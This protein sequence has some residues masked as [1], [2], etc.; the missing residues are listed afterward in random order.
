MSTYSVYKLPK[1][2]L[3]NLKLKDQRLDDD[4]ED[5]VDIE[6]VAHSDNELFCQ[7]CRFKAEREHFRSDWHRYN[8]KKKVQMQNPITLDEFEEKEDVSSIDSE[9][10]DEESLSV[11]SPQ[12]HFQLNETLELKVYKQILAQE[13]RFVKNWKERL[14]NLQQPNMKF[15]IIMIASGHFSGAVI[16][17][18]TGKFIEHKTF[19]RY[20]TR[21]KQGGAQSSK[22]SKAKSA[23]GQI[24]KYNENALIEEIQALLKE[25]KP[26][27]QQSTLI[28]VRA[29]AVMRRIIYFDETILRPTDDRVRSFPFTTKRPTLSEITRCYELITL[30]QPTIIIKEEVRLLKESRVEKEVEQTHL[31]FEPEETIES[32]P[33]EHELKLIEAIKKN[34]LEFLKQNM[35]EIN[36]IFSDSYGV[37]YLH[38]AACSPNLEIID[39]LLELG[40]DP[41]IKNTKGARAYDYSSSKPVRDVFRRFMY[42]HPTKY[43]Y[44]LAN[45][46]APL[47]PEMEEQQLEKER[48]K[49]KK[50][51]VKKKLN[52][53]KAKEESV[54]ELLGSLSKN[55]TVMKLGVMDKQTLGMTP[56]EKMRF[57]REKRAV[58]A[59]SRFRSSQNKCGACGKSLE[60]IQSFDKSIYRYC[61][62]D[63]LKE[64]NILF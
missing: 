61:S 28:F 2:V 42:R 45:I 30:V 15:T 63:C 29:P 43:D 53:P 22:G 11:G 19:H 40:C 36:T 16:D 49:K 14:E 39:Y 27:I 4:E 55:I 20:T 44:K 48:T 59:E 1:E 56:E 5:K 60:G 18:D 38:I 54:P 33:K 23:G 35:K 32:K 6:P 37:T 46:P 9:E 10:T 13:G 21:R 64:Q 58:S 50:E 3:S 41:T 51:K 8:I 31:I 25:W 7:T 34:R 62:I 26:L 52:P 12:V 47:S 57:D 17:C 24:R